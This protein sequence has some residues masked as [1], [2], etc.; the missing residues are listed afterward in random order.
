MANA[1]VADESVPFL[2][3]LATR[4]AATGADPISFLK[5]VQGM[6]PGDFWVNLALGD[7][8]RGKNA[9][10]EA[11]RFPQ[12][13]L[14][15]R[16]GTG[17]VHYRLAVALQIS[18]TGSR[19]LRIRVN[20]PSQASRRHPPAMPASPT[21]SNLW[22]GTIRPSSRH[23]SPSA[24]I[25]DKPTI[26]APSPTTSRP[27]ADMLRPRTPTARPLHLPYNPFTCKILG[28]ISSPGLLLRR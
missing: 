21:A 18:P 24:T 26:T 25:R 17:V 12:A 11:I 16:P 22:A 4:A 3:A 23:G 2:L 5:R 20:G 1:P 7:A 9:P 8:L 13:A 27:R 15:V 6:H 10:A 19:R 14:A 28:P